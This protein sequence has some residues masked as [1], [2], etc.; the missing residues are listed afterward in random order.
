MQRILVVDD[1]ELNRELLCEMLQ[2]DYLI[3]TAKDGKQAMGKLQE[4]G[5]DMTAVLLD[6]QMPEMDGF[7]VIASMGREGYL[8]RIP[9]LIISS[10]SAAEVES[11][12]FELG[13]FDYIHKPFEPFVVRNRVKKAIELFA[14]KN[15]LGRRV[16]EQQEELLQQDKII[17][18][19]AGRLNQAKAFNLLMMEYRFAIMEVETRLK[20][21]NEEF[22]YQYK[23]NPFESIKS[24]LK[25]PE[26]IYEKLERKGYPITVENIREHLSDVAGLRIICSFP[27]DIYRLANLF[28]RQGDILLLKKKDYIQ[29]PKDNGYRSLHLILSVP[30]FLSN[31]KKYVKTELQFRTIAMDFWASL[32]HKMKYKKDVDNAEEIVA[33]L[34]NCADTIEQLDHQMQDI[35][36]KIDSGR[37]AACTDFM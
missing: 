11:Q 36:N 10:E 29:H 37:G 35:R 21:L 22:S 26:S 5:N 23:R 25:K 24:R 6:L 32:E 16:R 12:C 13:V 17:Q 33:Q 28:T 2:R 8:E 20:V 27:D 31:E 4:Y 34:K 19:Q 14:R 1:A 18:M 3:E 30:V 7:E 15:E 9:V